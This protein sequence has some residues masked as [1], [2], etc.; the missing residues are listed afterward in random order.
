MGKFKSRLMTIIAADLIGWR[1]V[2]QNEFI[3]TVWNSIDEEYIDGY[4]LRVKFISVDYYPSLNHNWDEHYIDKTG[5]G[6]YIRM[7]INNEV[8]I[9]R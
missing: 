8:K 4:L 9:R 5:T 2:E 3:G 7:T 1:R 6:N